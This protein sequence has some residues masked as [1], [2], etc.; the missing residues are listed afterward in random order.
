M[1]HKIAYFISPHGYGH[2]ARA[3]AVM[4]AIQMRDASIQFEIFTRVPRWFFAESLAGPFGYHALLTDIGL[5]QKTSLEEDLPETIRRLDDFLPFNPQQIN[6][7]AR[8]VNRLECSLVMCDIAP[9]GIA[10]AKAAGVPSVLVENFTWDW[11]Y[12]GYTSHR[13]QLQPHIDYL[14]P[15]FATADYHIQTEPVC[16]PRPADLT[17]T[18]IGRKVRNTAG[19][20]RARLGLSNGAKMVMMTMGGMNWDYSFLERLERLGDIYLVA[21]GNSG[22]TEHRGNLIS[23]ARNSGIFHPDLVN[24]SSAIIGKTGYSTLAEVYQAGIP[25]GYISRQMF[26]EAPVLETFIQ[27]RMAGLP[28]TEAQL[29]NGDW[30]R[31]VPELLALPRTP[32]PSANGAGQVARFICNLLS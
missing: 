3:S 23:L 21:A 31:K 22:Q 4:A 29:Q 26:R 6:N 24:A 5:V 30:L 16:L 1:P 17:T 14:Q 15:L 7:L 28:F 11:I 10:V 19:Q 18:P 12:Q 27:T 25:F 32:P 9:M 13:K 2:A 8:Q 20:I